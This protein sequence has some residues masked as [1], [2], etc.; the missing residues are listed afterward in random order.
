VNIVALFDTLKGKETAVEK[1]SVRRPNIRGTV[2][3]CSLYSCKGEKATLPSLESEP[4]SQSQTQQERTGN[5][6]LLLLYCCPLVPLWLESMCHSVSRTNTS[7]VDTMPRQNLVIRLVNT[8]QHTWDLGFT[9]FG[10]PPVHFGILYRRFVEQQNWITQQTVS[11]FFY[12]PR[13]SC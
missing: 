1:K 2:V 13:F 5:R 11:L 6:C 4:I 10:G 8:V 7:K 12:P 3:S 9:S